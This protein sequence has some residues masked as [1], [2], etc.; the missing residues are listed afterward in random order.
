MI[1][2]VAFACADTKNA[3]FIALIDTYLDLDCE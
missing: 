2:F 3:A 1:T